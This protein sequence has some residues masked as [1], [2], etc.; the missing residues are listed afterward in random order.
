MSCISVLKY[1]FGSRIPA[2]SKVEFIVAGAAIMMFSA[3][4]VFLLSLPSSI[5]IT[6]LLKIL[7]KYLKSNCEEKL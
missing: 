3:K 2:L 5:N 6:H 1:I 4:L 7:G